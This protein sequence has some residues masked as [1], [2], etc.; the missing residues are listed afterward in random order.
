MLCGAA[1]AEREIQTGSY[2]A[3]CQADLYLFGKPALVGDI[4]CCTDGRMQ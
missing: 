1:D 4:A 2:G 3:P